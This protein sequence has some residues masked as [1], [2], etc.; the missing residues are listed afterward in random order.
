M[1]RGE[2]SGHLV[3]SCDEDLFWN[4]FLEGDAVPNRERLDG[5]FQRIWAFG[6]KVVIACRLGGW[7]VDCQDGRC[8]EWADDW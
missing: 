3:N 8:E 5:R 4:V 6:L 2:E 7:Y 1:A